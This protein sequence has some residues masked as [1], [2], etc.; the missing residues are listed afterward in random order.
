[1]QR[2][3]ILGS[4]G[5]IG[6]TSLNVIDLHADKFSIFALVAG[7]NDELMF[8]Q[9]IKYQPR[10]VVMA[11]EEARDRLFKKLKAYFGSVG[12]TLFECDIL[13]GEKSMSAVVAMDEVDQVIAAI[14]GG[15]GLIPTLAAVNAGKRI[16]LANKESLVMCG[17]LFID[18]VKA[19]NAELL[20]ID[21][22]HNAI[23][24]GLSAPLQ[25]SLGYC[26]LQAH[27]V[28]SI[29]LTGSGGP[30]LNLPLA[31]FKEVTVEQAVAHPRWN[32][33]AKIS[34]DSATMMNKGLEYI[35]AR[36]LFNASQA[37]IEVVLH[38]QSIIHSMVRYH[39]GSVIAQMGTAD[40][41][42]PIT[43]ALNYPNRIRS[44]AK[45]LDFFTTEPLTFSEPEQAR[46]PCLFLAKEACFAG[47]VATTIL[48]AANEVIVA[49]FLNKK[50]P[51]SD[52]F[53][54]NHMMQSSA[55]Y[56]EPKTVEAL[57]DID[58]EIRIKTSELIAKR[59]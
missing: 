48:N 8:E 28:S 45:K 41:S 59:V 2:V 33:G 42:I 50:I 21:S 19:S 44:P 31:Q 49:A 17:E 32:M 15:A 37:E 14:V 27:G 18:A 55:S 54:L 10:Y 57:L 20:P 6:L 22:E 53:T 35:E 39:D 7:Q 51:F 43:H 11:T 56:A 24:Q 40:M 13:F 12:S 58:K 30:F 36:W 5:S 26:E 3:A 9:L 1:M 46:F 38:P 52:I 4:T 23:F 34:V 25:Q 16:L 29:I 47:Q